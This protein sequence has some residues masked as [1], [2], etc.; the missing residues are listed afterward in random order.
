M[1][2]RERREKLMSYYRQVIAT[3][4]QK[5]NSEIIHTESRIVNLEEAKDKFM[6][7]TQRKLEKYH[8]KVKHITESSQRTI[9]HF[10]ALLIA[11]ENEDQDL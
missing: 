1:E 4:M 8:D 3:N 10:Q 5:A 2:R 9:S 7:E 6:M 11:L